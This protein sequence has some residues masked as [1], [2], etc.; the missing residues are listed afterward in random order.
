M[1]LNKNWSMI[2]CCL[3]SFIGKRFEVISIVNGMVDQRVVKCD[4]F[5]M[6][7][8]RNFRKV[9]IEWMVEKDLVKS[10][11]NKEDGRRLNCE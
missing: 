9:Q 4:G 2:C 10:V 3:E 6:G 8:S 1:W 11:G 5:K 7:Q